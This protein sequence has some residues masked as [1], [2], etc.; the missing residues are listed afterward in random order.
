MTLSCFGHAPPLSAG[1]AVPE[2]T[3]VSPI[4]A[5]GYLAEAVTR[6][7]GPTFDVGIFPYDSNNTAD[8]WEGKV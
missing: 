1:D 2:E 3:I 6:T 7:M 4:G 5:A 8:V